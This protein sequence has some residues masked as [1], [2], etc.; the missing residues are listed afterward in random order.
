MSVLHVSTPT[1]S[2]IALYAR[3]RATLARI[4]AANVPAP[5]RQEPLPCPPVVNVVATVVDLTYSPQPPLSIFLVVGDKQA[6]AHPTTVRDI[7]VTVGKYFGVSAAE[8][9]G[10]CRTALIVHWRHIAMHLVRNLLPHL[11]YPQIGRRFGDR[12]HTTILH[13][14]RKISALCLSDSAVAYD[15]A[16][17]LQAMGYNEAAAE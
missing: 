10:G 4:A 14:D 2:Q 7:Q 9:S 6:Y 13:A 11:S 16:N 3:H 17:L 15:V 5:V 8:L 1:P 12:D